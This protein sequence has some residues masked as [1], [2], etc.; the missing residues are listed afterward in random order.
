MHTGRGGAPRLYLLAVNATDFISTANG[1]TYTDKATGRHFGVRIKEGATDIEVIQ[2]KSPGRGPRYFLEEYTPNGRLVEDVDANPRFVDVPAAVWTKARATPS[3]A[4]RCIHRYVAKNPGFVPVL[5]GSGYS[6]STIFYPDLDACARAITN[7]LDTDMWVTSHEPTKHVSLGD[8]MQATLEAR[9]MMDRMPGGEQVEAA[10][11]DLGARLGKT[12]SLRVS[13]HC[14]GLRIDITD[15]AQEHPESARLL[16]C[17]SPEG[18]PARKP[19]F[20]RGAWVEAA[21]AIIGVEL[22]NYDG[23]AG[24]SYGLPAFGQRIGDFGQRPDEVRDLEVL[25]KMEGTSNKIYVYADVGGKRFFAWGRFAGGKLQTKPAPGSSYETMSK[26]RDGG[27]DRIAPEGIPD[28][29][30]RLMEA[31]AAQR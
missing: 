28:F 17:F 2:G 6:V 23:P 5:F 29:W 9:A 8:R 25:H 13:E 22:A 15:G 3:K 20:G 12:E 26:K 7:A 1:A 21:Q 19:G 16:V 10:A 11:R 31:A 18:R 30:S 27:N 14:G 4:W 24:T